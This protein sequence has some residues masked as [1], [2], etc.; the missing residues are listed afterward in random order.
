MKVPP[1]EPCVPPSWARG[2]HAQT[3]WGHVLPSHAFREASERIE[4]TLADGDRLV[5]RLVRGTSNHVV[6]IF[7]GLGGDIR[8]GYMSR[9]AQVVRNQGHTAWLVNHRGCGEG[10]SLATR[11]YHSGRGEDLSAVIALG[12]EKFPLHRHVAIGFSLSGN[13]LLCLLTGLRGEVWPDAAIAVNAPIDLEACARA[14]RT[15][16]NRLYDFNFVRSLEKLLRRRFNRGD[17]PEIGSRKLTRAPRL[18]LGMTLMEFDDYYTAP[19]AGFENN[20][21]Y[22]KSCSTHSHPAAGAV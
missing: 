8:A 11:P 22:Y 21:D 16:F 13:A 15:G 1:L 9:T 20:F 6:Y 12:R 4:I 19:A 17:L 18:G 2:G 5:T 14:L 10:E 7:H 3:L